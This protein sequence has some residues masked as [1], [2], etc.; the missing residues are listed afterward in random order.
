MSFYSVV[1]NIYKL[2]CFTESKMEINP[3]LSFKDRN[4]YFLNVFDD[5]F[6]GN[7]ISLAEGY[8]DA[9]SGLYLIG[10]GFATLYFQISSSATERGEQI[11]GGTFGNP[12]YAVEFNIYASSETLDLPEMKL[13]NTGSLSRRGL[14]NINLGWLRVVGKLNGMSFIESLC[15]SR[16]IKKVATHALEDEHNRSNLGR[17]VLKEYQER[18]KDNPS[19]LRKILEQYKDKEKLAEIIPFPALA[20]V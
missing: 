6:L 16:T 3:I 18:G 2:R 15:L 5:P 19:Y 1:R 17:L 14:A 9:E 4:E 8:R 11:I 13:N 20:R 12:S 7:D 10:D